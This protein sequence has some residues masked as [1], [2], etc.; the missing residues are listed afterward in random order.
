MPLKYLLRI[1]ACGSNWT[2]AP[3]EE[4]EKPP[5][6]LG[7]ASMLD[8]NLLSA[9]QGLTRLL[10]SSGVSNSQ[11]IVHHF[12]LQLPLVDAIINKHWQSAWLLSS[13][14]LRMARLSTLVAQIPSIMANSQGYPESCNRRMT[15][16]PPCPC[17]LTILSHSFVAA[18][19]TLSASGLTAMPQVSTSVLLVNHI[20]I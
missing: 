17:L 1:A 13:C 20:F 7:I 10:K 6:H 3:S 8:K 11:T 5:M 15:A 16:Q 19:E 2:L 4:H 14:S 12:I 9:S 18:H